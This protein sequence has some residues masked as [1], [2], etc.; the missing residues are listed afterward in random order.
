MFIYEIGV[1][2]YYKEQGVLW[3]A[4]DWRR[5]LDRWAKD[6]KIKTFNPMNTYQIEMNHTYSDKAIVE[7]NDYY[8]NKADIAVANMND[9]EKSPGSIYEIVRFKD[10][11]KPVIAFGEKVWS[12][13]INSC[14][15]HQC[16]SLDEC[17]ELLVNMFSQ[18]NF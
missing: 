8:I 15:T 17:I 13:H 6:N 16:D 9:I 12:P 10:L 7:Q 4:I 18:G 5:K 14:I 3:K 1:I 2:S 11:R